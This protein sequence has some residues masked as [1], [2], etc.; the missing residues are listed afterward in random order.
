MK[1]ELPLDVL[2]F[3]CLTPLPGSE[4]HKVLTQKGVWMDPDMNKYDLEHVVAEHKVMTQEEWHRVYLDAWDIYYTREH[5]RTILRRSAALGTAMHRLAAVLFFFS[6]YQA[7]EKLHPIQGGLFRL[8][9]RRDRRPACR[10]SRS[11]RSIRSIGG[12][13]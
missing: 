9:H 6:S 8:K 5:M 12:R 1:R 13:S 11:G 3:F 2:E 4:D 7:V 10:C